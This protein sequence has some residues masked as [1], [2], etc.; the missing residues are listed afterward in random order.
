M[1]LIRPNVDLKWAEKL[2]ANKDSE[3]FKLPVAIE[4][5]KSQLYSI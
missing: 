1:I 5:V 2:N 3:D 4:P